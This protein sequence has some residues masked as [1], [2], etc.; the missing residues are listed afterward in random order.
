MDHKNYLSNN[1]TLNQLMKITGSVSLV[2]ML[3]LTQR[4]VLQAEET[5]TPTTNRVNLEPISVNYNDTD[6]IAKIA[7]TILKDHVNLLSEFKMVE[8]S[9][10]KTVY[11]LEDYIVSVYYE[12]NS[13]LGVKDV[14][15]T[16]ET[17]F[18]HD[19]PDDQKIIVQC[20]DQC[21]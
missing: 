4:G 16:I 14:K 1:M 19:R 15:L 21:H 2:T 11:S 20:K 18:T 5:T 3:A 10:Y 12:A 7:K 9:Q 13:G 8:S 17:K 6:A